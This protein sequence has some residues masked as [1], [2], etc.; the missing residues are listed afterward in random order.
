MSKLVSNAV[1]NN[2]IISD[3]VINRT[4]LPLE[5]NQE[6]EVETAQKE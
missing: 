4:H 1:P 6:I 5:T 2:N 3:L